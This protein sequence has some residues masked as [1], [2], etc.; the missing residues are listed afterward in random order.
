MVL[1]TSG[2]ANNEL[3]FE[4]EAFRDQLCMLP[5]VIDV[6]FDVQSRILVFPAATRFFRSSIKAVQRRRTLIDVVVMSDVLLNVVSTVLVVILCS[7]KYP[8]FRLFHFVL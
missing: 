6:G 4:S 5:S 8:M 1:N 2:I 3:R 7:A